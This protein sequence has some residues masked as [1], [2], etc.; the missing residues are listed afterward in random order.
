[1]ILV[2]TSGYNYPEWK[3]SFYP[4]DLPAAKM[5]P[6]YAERFPSVEINASFY[7]MP[8]SKVVAGWAAQ[9]P[10]AFRF[11]LKANRR[12]T[13]DRRLKD[14]GDSV[15]FFVKTARELGPQLGAVLFQTPPNLK[16]N[17]EV[18]DAFLATVPEG[19]VAAFE[20]RHDSW[21]SEEVYARL[22]TRNLA[23]CIADTEAR[24]TPVIATA[25]YAYL[26]LRDE[27]YD[28]VAIRRWTTVA[29]DLATTCRDVFVYFKHEDAG[30]GAAFG[31][32]MLELLG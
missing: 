9:V 16:C 20:F 12:I 27:G 7:R 8:T 18:F 15:D 24:S 30:K 19:L 23:L 21:L 28:D 4:P 10:P 13:H 17:L 2:G 1:M 22:R 25:D 26:R 31:Q 29:Q 5:L 32:R 11:T 14:V 3:G 6:F